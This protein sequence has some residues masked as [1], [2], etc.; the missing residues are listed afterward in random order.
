MTVASFAITIPSFA[1]MIATV[2]AMIATVTI[3]I[4]TVE[5]TI[6][7]VAM[8]IATVT[9]VRIIKL[10]GDE[11]QCYGR[12]EKLALLAKQSFYELSGND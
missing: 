9:I 6:A 11:G 3:T 7:T 8:T 5:I 4:A 2:T 12:R 1:K 10:Y